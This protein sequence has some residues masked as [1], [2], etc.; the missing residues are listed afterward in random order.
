MDPQDQL[1]QQDQREH[2]GH[3]E[4][5]LAVLDPP[6]HPVTVDQQELQAQLDQLVHQALM[7][8]RYSNRAACHEIELHQFLSLF[9]GGKGTPGKKGPAGPAGGPGKGGPAGANGNDGGP[10][11]AGPPGAAGPPGG[12]GK[13]G[14][15]GPAGDAG[16]PGND[17]Q[18]V[19]A[20]FCPFT[21]LFMKAHHFL[22]NN[23]PTIL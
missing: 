4:P 22:F 12:D 20:L 21:I 15:P 17:A 2:L 1:D 18:Y 5:A 11:P 9:Q 3:Q 16:L 23:R 19:F 13:P 6:D 14:G 10:G 7:A 8:L